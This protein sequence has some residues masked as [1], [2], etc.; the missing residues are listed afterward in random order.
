MKIVNS[1]L[2]L[3]ALVMALPALAAKQP[4]RSEA[5]LPRFT[6][7][8]D[9]KPS[10]LLLADDTAFATFAKPVRA[11]IERTLAD[12][13]IQDK[14]TLRD[15]L[16]TLLN[17]QT[18]AGEDQAALTTVRKIRALEDK[19]DAKLWS[20]GFREAYLKARI[21]TRS[22]DDQALQA[23][24]KREYTA[25]MRAL[26]WRVV[27][28]LA[29]A[30]KPGFQ[31]FTPTYLEGFI[32]TEVDPVAAETHTLGNDPAHTL[33][34]LRSILKNNIPVYKMG[35]D[36]I[37]TYIAAHDQPMPNIWAARD[38]DLMNRAE[39]TP[40]RVAIWDTG[41]D[42]Q[43][44]A[45]Q[46]FTDPNPGPFDPYGLAFDRD[47]NPS[48]GALM[49]LDEAQQRDY[50]LFVDVLKGM[51]DMRLN[52]D[53]PEADALRQRLATMQPEEI[54]GFL[55]KYRFYSYYLHGSHVAGIAARGNPAIRL[56]AARHTDDWRNVPALPTLES[57]QRDVAMEQTFV[58]YFKSRGVRVVNMSWGGGPSSVEEAMEKNGAGKDAE[59]RKRMAREIFDIYKAG[60]EKALRSAPEILFIAA[61]GNSNDDAGFN[62]VIPSSFKLPNLLTVG[63][64]D[65]AG[66]EANF[67]SYGDTVRVH[68]NGYAVLS[69]V[70]NG[71]EIPLSGTSMAAP[72]VTNLAAKL[73]ALRPELKPE[74]VID[75]IVRGATSSPD[76]RRHLI[77]PKASVTLLE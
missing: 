38:I 12:Y 43:A 76:G 64:V 75:L 60:L 6:Y 20:G 46:M 65:Q 74:Q 71:R 1:A 67:T 18:L 19:P 63:A 27:G 39:L 69:R 8:I 35:L 24:F 68:S 57:T 34:R 62:E 3:L 15:L 51:S 58:D 21:A 77:N 53:S 66:E 32:K 41:I 56:V 30:D 16:G 5:D 40:V 28:T 4:V 59:D 13:D 44:Y 25:F 7:P 54:P 73:L 47:S 14:A 42:P 52:I 48:H 9:R 70:P 23:A 61:A 55:E 10:E 2:V 11:D 72:Q 45:A 22:K 36:V 26:P 29:K 50:P 49:P 31:I 37:S 17:L 33:I